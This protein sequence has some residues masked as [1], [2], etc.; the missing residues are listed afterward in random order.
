M[1]MR[2]GGGACC[3]SGE[4]RVVLCDA[5][6]HVAAEISKLMKTLGFMT[7]NI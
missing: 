7:A 6:A 2:A 4:Y 5:I 3:D 1:C